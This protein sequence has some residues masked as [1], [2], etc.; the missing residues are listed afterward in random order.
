MTYFRAIRT[1]IGP[2]CLTAVFGMGT[3]VATW[4]WSPENQYIARH[5]W[6]ETLGPG[7]TRWFR[8]GCGSP[9]VNRGLYVSKGSGRRLLV[10]LYLSLSVCERGANPFRVQKRVNAVKRLA[11]STGPLKV[12]LLVH[13]RP[14]DLV[15]FQEP[16]PI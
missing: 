6:R 14:I 7:R 16:S 8:G 10:G 9:P 13:I 4:V 12:L 2:K 11:V 5:L 15:I 1:I 3:G